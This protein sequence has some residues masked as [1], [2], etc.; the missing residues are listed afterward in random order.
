[1]VKV[2]FTLE[3]VTKAQNGSTDSITLLFILTSALGGVSGQHHSPA[4][5]YAL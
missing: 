3:Q 4:A 2:M 1:M 5:L